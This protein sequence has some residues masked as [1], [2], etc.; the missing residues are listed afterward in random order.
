MR[1]NVAQLL[2]EPIGATRDKRIE[3]SIPLLAA[4]LD[5]VQ[6]VAGAVR[7]LRTDAGVFVK[8]SVQAQVVVECCRCLTPFML[9]LEAVVEEEFRAGGPFATDKRE[10]EETEDPALLISDQHELDLLEVVR[11]QLLLALPM[12]P[13]CRPECAGLCPHCGQDLNDGP[14]ECTEE[15]DPRW[16][17]LKALQFSEEPEEGVE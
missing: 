7:L 14:C 1:Y 13:V 5:A 8:G 9:S 10:S 12:H 16:S 11:Q 2:R 4:G 17:A 6:P 3:G 15:P